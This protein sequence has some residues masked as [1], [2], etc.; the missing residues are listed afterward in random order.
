MSDIKLACDVVEQVKTICDKH[1]NNPGELINILHEAQHLHGYL[2]EEMQRI[3]ASKLRIPVS[4][5]YGVVTFY[6]FFT[7]TPKGKHPISRLYGHGM[8]RTGVREIIGRIQTGTWHRS[9][10][11]HSRRKIFIRLPALRRRLRISSG[12]DDR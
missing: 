3:I 4:K 9:R 1:G 5:V 2:P 6:T 11:N 8:L 12:S 7:M 10:R